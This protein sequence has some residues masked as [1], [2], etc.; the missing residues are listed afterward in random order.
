MRTRKEI[1]EEIGSRLKR[2]LLNSLNAYIDAIESGENVEPD[3]WDFYDEGIEA[4]LWALGYGMK[5]AECKQLLII[6]FILEEIIPLDT[7]PLDPRFYLK[8]ALSVNNLDEAYDRLKLKKIDIERL[9]ERA[10]S[11]QSEL[12]KP[13]KDFAII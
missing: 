4:L 6:R 3:I 11:I 12:I 7:D 10:E 5:D 8:N 2:T 1:L 9:L 13:C